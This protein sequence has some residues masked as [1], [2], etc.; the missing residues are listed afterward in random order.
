MDIPVIWSYYECMED[1]Q[2]YAELLEAVYQAYEKSLD[3]DVALDVVALTPEV[4]IR[5]TTDPDLHARVVLCDSRVKENLV[6]KLRSLG[7]NAQNEGVRLQALKELGRTV[8]PK[9][10]KEGGSAP[11][12]I[13][14]KRLPKDVSDEDLGAD[15]LDYVDV[16]DFPTESEYCYTRGV[17]LKKLPKA[18]CEMMAAKRQ[19]V[20]IRRGWSDDGPLGTF[21][22]KLAANAGDFSLVDKHELG[23]PNGDPIPITLITRRVVDG[24]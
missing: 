10:F 16:A 15:M 11:P 14:L 18:G 7:D 1:T 6:E 22:T 2:N 23:G 20:M 24:K 12:P 13:P 9:R 5:L 17:A 4:R 3:L 19:A 8:Y 21:L